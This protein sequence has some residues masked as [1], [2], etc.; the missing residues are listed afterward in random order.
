MEKCNF[1]GTEVELPI[2]LIENVSF[3]L[4]QVYVVIFYTTERCNYLFNPHPSTTLK[5]LAP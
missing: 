1:Q 2:D 4:D 5:A 3:R